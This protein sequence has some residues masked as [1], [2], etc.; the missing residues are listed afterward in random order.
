MMGANRN[1]LASTP[2]FSHSEIAFTRGRS[3]FNPD[4][5][6]VAIVSESFARRHWRERIPRQ[7]L[8]TIT[9]VK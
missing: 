3:R 5:R 9:N 7:D 6:D 4:E 1:Q 2:T 8:L